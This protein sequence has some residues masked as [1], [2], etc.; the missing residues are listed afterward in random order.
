MPMRLAVMGMPPAAVVVCARQMPWDDALSLMGQLRERFPQVE[1]L[2]IGATAVP[3]R[4]ACGPVCSP[5][6]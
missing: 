4:L 1:V 2:A 3:G 6:A 5:G